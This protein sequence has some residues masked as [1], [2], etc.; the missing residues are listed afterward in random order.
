MLGFFLYLIFSRVYREVRYKGHG[1]LLSLRI[2]TSFEYNL[3]FAPF[4]GLDI[5]IMKVFGSWSLAL[6]FTTLLFAGVQASVDRRDD[7]GATPE[8]LANQKR[9]FSI[10]IVCRRLCWVTWIGVY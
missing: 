10:G 2:G 4:Y 9:S 1:E 8:Q 3:D 6:S 7:T 5:A